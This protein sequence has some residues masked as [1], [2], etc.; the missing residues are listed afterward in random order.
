MSKNPA[1]P[2]TVLLKGLAMTSVQRER[3]LKIEQ[4]KQLNQNHL[5]VNERHGP[6]KLPERGMTLYKST[7][8]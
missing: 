5:G 7:L 6:I 3:L 8:T 2:I 1:M 4:A